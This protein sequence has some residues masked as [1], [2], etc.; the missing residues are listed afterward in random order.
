MIVNLAALALYDPYTTS[1]S[2]IIGDGTN[3]S[4]ANIGL[5]TLPSLPTPLL[6]TNVL[7]V[8]AVSNNLISVSIFVPITLLM[9]YIFT[10]SFRC[11]IVTRGH[12]GSLA[13]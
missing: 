2:V 10:L 12:F 9:S 4:I 13:T 3:L 5:F 8:H 11:V 7:H 1:N 6:F